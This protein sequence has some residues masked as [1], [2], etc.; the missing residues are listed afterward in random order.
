MEKPSCRINRLLVRLTI[1]RR[2]H[3]IKL[4]QVSLVAVFVS[5]LLQGCGVYRKL[6]ITEVNPADGDSSSR[7]VR[8]L[9]RSDQ[10]EAQVDIQRS[11]CL[12]GGQADQRRSGPP[13]IV[14]TLRGGQ[15]L[16]IFE[17]AQYTDPPVAV[18]FSARSSESK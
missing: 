12:G 14:G 7:A 4:I 1:S 16:V 3:L 5:L 17:D 15:F 18:T 10:Y 6:K 9:A 2:R 13:G 11:G 8:Q